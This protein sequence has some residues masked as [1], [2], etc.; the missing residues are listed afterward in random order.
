MLDLPL[1][2]YVFIVVLKLLIYLSVTL[3]VIVPE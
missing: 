2:L 1:K 3:E